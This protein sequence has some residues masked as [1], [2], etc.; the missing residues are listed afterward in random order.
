M[1]ELHPLLAAI[2]ASKLICL[3]AEFADGR[4]MLELSISDAA[5]DIIYNKRFKP[6]KI[7]DWGV[8]PHGITPAMVADAPLF[9]DCIEEIQAIIDYADY[10]SGF[11]L[12]NDFRRLRNEG[13]SIAEDKKVIEVKDWFWT[14]YG[15]AHGFDY[16]KGISNQSVAAELGITVDEDRL[17]ASDYDIELSLSSLNRILYHADTGSA[18]SFDGLYEAVMAKFRVDKEEYDRQQSAGY[19]SIL[20]KDDG[21]WIKFNKNRPYESRSL[22]ALIEVESRKEAMIYMSKLFLNRIEEGN[23]FVEKLSNAKLEKFKS[24]SNTFSPEDREVQSKLL[25]LAGKFSK[26]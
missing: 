20:Q 3:D 24:Y 26:K 15:L 2:E 25:R 16:Q 21:Y 17:H 12:E 22:I 23:F 6:A 14:V 4:Y 10:I 18:N 9:R 1:T 11:A 7:S 19:C 8:I 13:I 5:G